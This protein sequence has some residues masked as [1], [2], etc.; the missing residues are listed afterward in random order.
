MS[1]CRIYSTHPAPDYLIELGRCGQLFHQHNVIH[2]F[3]AGLLARRV[4][5]GLTTGVHR[6]A[7]FLLTAP[8]P[9]AAALGPPTPR[10]WRQFRPRLSRRTH[11]SPRRRYPC[12]PGIRPRLRVF[13]LG[14]LGVL[15]LS[16]VCPPAVALAWIDPSTGLDHPTRVTRRAEIPEQNWQRGHR[17]VDLALPPGADV[18]AAA[19][20]V[21]A[22]AGSVA[23][24][25]TVAIDHAGGIRTTYQPVNASVQVGDIVAEGGIIGTVSPQPVSPRAGNHDGL[26]W[27]A[28]TGPDSYIDPLTLLRSPQ[29][30]LKPVGEPGRKPS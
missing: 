21:V 15:A 10:R 13:A 25:P 3:A 5:V 14:A 30:R 26:H 29:I 20:G 11:P 12:R 6:L 17:G 9:T 2:S 28:K 19:G 22:F 24:T 8:A 18:R 23:G 1:D 7:A 4:A 27:G 16:A